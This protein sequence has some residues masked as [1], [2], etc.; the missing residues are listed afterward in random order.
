MVLAIKCIHFEY[1][2]NRRKKKKKGSKIL[3][4]PATMKI[5]AGSYEVN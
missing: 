3:S 2:A 4:C 5:G 1:S